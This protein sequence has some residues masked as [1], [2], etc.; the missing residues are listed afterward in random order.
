MKKEDFRISMYRGQKTGIFEH[1]TLVTTATGDQRFC[2]YSH[3]SG[4]CGYPALFYRLYIDMDQPL[5][6]EAAEASNAPQ[7]EQGRTYWDHKA[8][9]SMVA[10]G[11]VWQRKR[12]EGERV[13]LPETYTFVLDMWWR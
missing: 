10:C 1:P 13:Y 7:D 5:W 3:C 2:A 4:E 6:R 12:W 11:P 9:G 8:H